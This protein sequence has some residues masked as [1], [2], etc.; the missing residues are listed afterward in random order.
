LKIE[1]ATVGYFEGVVRDYNIKI[2]MDVLQQLEYLADSVE[3]WRRKIWDQG[4][5]AHLKGANY[6]KK[7]DSFVN[8]EGSAYAVR[9]SSFLVSVL[10][11]V[12][13]IFL[14]SDE[15]YTLQ[16]QSLYS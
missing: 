13:F 8:F 7:G 9:M 15:E 3:G 6:F 12:L 10:N 14:I 16:F 4:F 5:M 1:D 2:N 11:V